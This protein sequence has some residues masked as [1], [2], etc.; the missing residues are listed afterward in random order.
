MTVW[1]SIFTAPILTRSARLWWGQWGGHPGGCR[2]PAWLWCGQQE[3]RGQRGRGHCGRRGGEQ[4]HRQGRIRQRGQRG[5]RAQQPEQQARRPQQG[6]GNKGGVV[7]VVGVQ[8]VVIV[9]IGGGIWVSRVG[10]TCGVGSRGVG[11][12]TEVVV[13]V[14]VGISFSLSIGGWLSLCLTALAASQNSG[15]STAE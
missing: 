3:R 10:I 9:G 6:G 8:V 12:T 13:V 11:I 1:G 2:S 5:P 14:K 15:G 4:Q 7:V